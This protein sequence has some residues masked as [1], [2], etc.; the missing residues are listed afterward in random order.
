MVGW[1]GGWLGG[2][3]GGGD[4]LST[5]PRLTPS[6]RLVNYASPYLY[7][8]L[9]DQFVLTLMTLIKNVIMQCDVI[10]VIFA[11]QTKLNISRKKRATKI[12]PKR[13]HSHFKLSLQCNRENVR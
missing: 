9:V 12:L 4:A 7:A 11:Y 2:W 13:L 8:E 5:D 3:L 6:G 1:V 10:R